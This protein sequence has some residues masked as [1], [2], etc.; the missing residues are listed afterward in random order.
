MELLINDNNITKVQLIEEQTTHEELALI[1]PIIENSQI[2]N[3][4]IGL[5]KSLRIR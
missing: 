4:V 5:H 1:K 2:N 3:E